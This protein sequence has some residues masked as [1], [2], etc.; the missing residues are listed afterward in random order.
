MLQIATNAPRS[1]ISYDGFTE[2]GE[3]IKNHFL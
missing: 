2:I 3:Y 1:S